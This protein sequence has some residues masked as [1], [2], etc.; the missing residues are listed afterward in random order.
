MV[1]VRYFRSLF[2]GHLALVTLAPPG[3]QVLMPS[4]VHHFY[5]HLVNVA[6]YAPRHLTL[7]PTRLTDIAANATKWS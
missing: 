6:A 4:F 5:F 2:T 3:A 7:A 1:T